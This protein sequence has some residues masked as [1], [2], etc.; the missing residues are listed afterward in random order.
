MNY[1]KHYGGFKYRNK[2]D[3]TSTTNN[4]VSNII[5]SAVVATVIKD[6]SSEKSKI[7]MLINKIIHPTQI[8]NKSKIIEVDYETVSEK[9]K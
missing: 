4:P 3:K 9:E 6:I 2:H 1:G 7:K 5:F 8:E